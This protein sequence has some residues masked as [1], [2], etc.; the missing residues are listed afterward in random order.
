MQRGFTCNGKL[1]K[2]WVS[3]VY[4]SVFDMSVIFFGLSNI[5]YDSVSVSIGF[6]LANRV[7]EGENS[8]LNRLHSNFWTMIR[9]TNHKLF[10]L[11]GIPCHIY[12]RRFLWLK[13]LHGILKMK[14]AFFVLTIFQLILNF[15]VNLNY[16]LY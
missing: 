2:W 4:G 11:D 8:C 7:A 5:K 10:I 6:V 16:Y 13:A 14:L 15:T 9:M 12:E 1:K 3:L